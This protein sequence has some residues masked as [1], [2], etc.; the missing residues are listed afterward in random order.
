MNDDRPLYGYADIA[1]VGALLAD[2][3]RARVVTSL[4]D[5]RALPA[6]VLAAEAGVAASTASEHLSRL[7]DGGLLTVER[8]G[9][10]RYYRLAN[11]RV[12]AAIEALAALAPTR[13]VRSLR[14]STRAAALRR[15]RSCY[16]HLAGRLGVA[17]TEALLTHE[18]LVRTDG[19]PGTV[20]A[21]GD[22][23]SAPLR[24][25]PYRLGPNAESLFDRL[26]VDLE[27]ALDQRRPL[28][29]FCVDWSEQRHHLSGALGA[30]VFARMES[31][32]WVVRHD[33]RRALRLTDSGAR[34]LDRVLG[35]ELAA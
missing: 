18:A 35:V 8:S 25:H 29:R 2:A 22:P 19:I 33:S 15:A 6:S 4:A 24:E 32:G 27:S 13:P 5:G 12:G 10:H 14:E 23:I 26:G 11:E 7:V 28:L 1:A 20:R 31:A 9:R 30:A 21:E 16:D 17:V 34:V 3:T